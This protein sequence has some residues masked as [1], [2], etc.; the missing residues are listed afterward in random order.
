MAKKK[1][2]NSSKQTNSAPIAFPLKCGACGGQTAGTDEVKTC[3]ECGRA[4]SRSATG[5]LISKPGIRSKV[6]REW[7]PE[8]E[9]LEDIAGEEGPS[10][11]DP[12]VD[13]VDKDE[14]GPVEGEE[15]PVTEEGAES[16]ERATTPVKPKEDKPK[17]DKPKKEKK[18]RAK[19]APKAKADTGTKPPKDKARADFTPE[20]EK[21]QVAMDKR[22]AT[23]RAARIA[24]LAT[25][26]W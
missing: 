10:A 4:Y 17:E 14:P 13:N 26:K 20:E 15:G 23:M 2:G 6:P 9:T 3:M 22:G 12:F 7:E 11:D 19:K 5:G 16:E 1:N 8:P 18:A 24:K 21:W 25:Q